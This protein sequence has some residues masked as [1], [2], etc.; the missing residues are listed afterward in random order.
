MPKVVKIKSFGN[1]EVM[2][3]TEEESS[4]VKAGEARI[5]H[6]AV[7]LNYLD[8]MHRQGHY[9]LPLP[10]G[11]GVAGCG[12]I[13]EIRSE[14]SELA[15]G[16]LVAYAGIPPGSY[17]QERIVPADR[18]VKL[19]A[20]IDPAV[21]AAALQHGITA[22]L[23]I[24]DVFA[25]A[26]G[27]FVLVHA[28]AGGV[29]TVLCQWAK[30]IGATVIGTVGNQEKVSHA[31]EHGCD[32]VLVSTVENVAE[33]V[34]ALTAGRGVNVAYDS[35]GAD[36]FESSLN[37]LAFRGMLVS[38]GSASGDPSPVPVGDLAEVGSVYLTRPRFIHY[39]RTRSDLLRYSEAFFEAI[40]NG[41][42]V[43]IGQ[44]YNIDEIVR[45]HKDVESRKT[46]GSSVI[47]F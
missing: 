5:E 11:L 10:T 38:F 22:A 42:K 40:R 26:P 20:D 43:P 14:L 41:L 25:V 17:A 24:K 46:K 27:H 31:L 15:V 7:G 23:L 16:D 21:A 3:I 2:Q 32:H 6:L 44:T 29:G 28:A 18:L 34:R 35:V 8:I 9:P 47:A 1:A 19:P 4:P 30:A 45:A 12:I 13:R 39:T 33:R 36:S 37:S